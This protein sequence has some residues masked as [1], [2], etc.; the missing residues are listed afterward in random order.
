VKLKSRPERKLESNMFEERLLR[1]TLGFEEDKVTEKV[2][3]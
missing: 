2:K 1:G 3:K